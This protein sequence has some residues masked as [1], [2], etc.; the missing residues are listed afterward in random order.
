MAQDISIGLGDHFDSFIEAQVS[1]GRYQSANEVLR[2][3]LR[4]LEAQEIELDR[5]RTALINGEASGPAEP[6]DRH[7]FL[8]ELRQ[9]RIDGE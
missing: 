8:A 5:I 3:G 7:E 9:Q 6:I 1:T 2:A 4:L